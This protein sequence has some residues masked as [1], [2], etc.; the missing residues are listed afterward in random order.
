DK[1]NLNLK[2]N[3]EICEIQSILNQL[4]ENRVYDISNKKCDGFLS[5]HIK[6]L[7]DK[8]NNLLTKVANNKDGDL[9]VF[10]C[11]E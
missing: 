1:E 10:N 6:N 3:S 5:T 2:Y 8:I 9:E 11:K 4:Y 7:T